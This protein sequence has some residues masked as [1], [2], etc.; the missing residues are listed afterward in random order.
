MLKY[1]ADPKFGI[2]NSDS[3]NHVSL[4]QEAMDWARLEFEQNA[5]KAAFVAWAERNQPGLTLQYQAMPAWH[6]L[7]IG[8]I[9]YLINRGSAPP[10]VVDTWF[11]AQLEKLQTQFIKVDDSVEEEVAI[12]SKDRRLFEYVDFYSFIDAI[13]VKYADDGE[14]IESKLTE[15]LRKIQPNQIMLRKLYAHFKEVLAAAM[16]DKNNSF[17]EA[18]IA[19]LILVVNIIAGASGNAKVAS[20]NASKASKKAVKASEK[21]NVKLIDS[22]TNMASISPAQ[23]PGATLAVIYNSKDRKAMVYYA[24][25]D[26]TLNIKGTKIINFDDKRSFAKTLRKPKDLLPGLR[27]AATTRRVDVIL[28]DVN[29]KSHTVNGR[30]GKEMLIVKIFK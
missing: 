19:P 3:D 26:E 7:T 9:A 6:Y 17:A 5:L 8:R 15:R 20:Y 13:R 27:D 18:T 28:A 23:L 14:A 22:D 21:V 2:I 25:S 29:G 24:N 11:K 16:Q 4:W 10:A 30:I 1:N 12:T